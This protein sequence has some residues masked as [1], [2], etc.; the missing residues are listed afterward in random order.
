MSDSSEGK[1][2]DLSASGLIK[3]LFGQILLDAKEFNPQV[4]NLVKKHLCVD[5]PHTKAGNNLAAELI[6][7]A[8]SQAEEQ[9]K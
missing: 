3:R 4:V 6:E 2:D 9:T 5:S 7:L 8:K 1:V